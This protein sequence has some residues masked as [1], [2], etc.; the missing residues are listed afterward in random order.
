MLLSRLFRRLLNNPTVSVGRRHRSPR[1]GLQPQLEPLESRELLALLGLAQECFKPDI[2]SGAV[3]NLSYTQVG[4][5]ANPVH[6]DAVPLSLALGNGATGTSLFSI[7]N[8]TA[9]TRQTRL[10][11]RLTNAGQFAAGVAG[12]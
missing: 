4:N 7:A 5:N 8:P 12:D 1:R 6:Y 3:T 11:M 10:D 9:G 2:A